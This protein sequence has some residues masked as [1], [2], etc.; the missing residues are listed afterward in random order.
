M[1][2]RSWLMAEEASNQRDDRGQVMRTTI[3]TVATALAIAVVAMVLPAFAAAD[4]PICHNGILSDDAGQGCADGLYEQTYGSG[5]DS[6]GICHDGI[7]SNDIGQ[8]CTN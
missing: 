6:A 4:A 3:K 2:H 5:S 7:L 1:S 8:G